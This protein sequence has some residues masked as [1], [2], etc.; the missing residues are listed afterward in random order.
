[1]SVT[2]GTVWI[3]PDYSTMGM[4][5]VMHRQQEVEGGAGMLLFLCFIAPLKE[6]NIF[7]RS[8]PW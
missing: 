8:L 3:S 7:D 2:Q 5:I 6:N 1:M 4:V